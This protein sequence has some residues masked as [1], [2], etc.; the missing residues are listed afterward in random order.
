MYIERSVVINKPKREVFDYIKLVRNQDHF[1]V[2]NMKDPGQ[3]VQTK[4]TDGMPGFVYTWDSQDKSVG[5]G[6]QEIRKVVE[7]DLVECELRF[8]RP[9]KNV[10]TSKFRVSE[11][12]PS[13]T[14]VSW[15]FDG[16]TKF[17][18]NLFSFVIKRMLGND[19]QK[20][21]DNLKAKLE[22]KS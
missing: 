1:S 9:M 18:M 22:K 15:D 6:S 11:A 4:G 16:P 14:L 10:A 13:S 20:S 8:E 17:P 3:K 2:W 19:M 12:G 7:G 5:A 21:L